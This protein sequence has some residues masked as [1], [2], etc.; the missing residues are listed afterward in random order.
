MKC[1]LDVKNCFVPDI[2]LKVRQPAEEEVKYFKDN[3]TLISFLYP[4]QNKSL[5]DQLAKKQMTVFG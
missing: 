4:V 2:I 1:I 3:S 5:V